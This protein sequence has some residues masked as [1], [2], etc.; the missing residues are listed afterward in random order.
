[1]GGGE[2]VEG[3]GGVER[4]RGALPASLHPSRRADGSQGLLVAR[5]TFRLED[6]RPVRTRSI[7]T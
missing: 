5:A 4:R 2:G 6:K 3:R 7:P 1:M